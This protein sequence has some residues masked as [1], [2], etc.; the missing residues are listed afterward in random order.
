MDDAPPPMKSTLAACPVCGGEQI[1]PHLDKPAHGEVWHVRKCRSCGHGFVANPPTLERLGEIQAALE[2]DTSGSSSGEKLA[3]PRDDLENRTFARRIA[4][5]T[6]ARGKTLDV[7]CGDGSATLCLSLEGFRPHLL[8]DFDPRAASTVEHIP[9]STFDR[10]AFEE[11]SIDAHGPFDVIVMSHVLEHALRP[12]DWLAHA[13]RLL[14]PQGLLAIGLPNFGGVY[15]FLGA[16]DPF[17]IP[18]VH[19]QYFTPS[20]MR[21]ALERSG[22]R[23]VRMESRSGVTL[24]PVDRV[25]NFRAKLTRRAWNAGAAV[26]NKTTRGIVL[27]AFAHI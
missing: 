11:L 6:P 13:R 21:R 26:L 15:R 3:P 27:W 14:S 25:L 7:G 1:V 9:D 20:S 17:L 12:L 18:P 22:L 24:T 2:A 16:R 8:I 10:I 5:L 19:L 4:S 23:V